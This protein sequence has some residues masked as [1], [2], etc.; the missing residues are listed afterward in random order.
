[1]L[2]PDYIKICTINGDK[3]INLAAYGHMIEIDH[4]LQPII[5][6]IC[7][8]APFGQT[9]IEPYGDP[10]NIAA[11]LVTLYNQNI[12]FFEDELAL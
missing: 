1:M 5:D 6:L 11:F 12:I 4:S 2:R 3:T 8:S 9:E 10:K 7:Q